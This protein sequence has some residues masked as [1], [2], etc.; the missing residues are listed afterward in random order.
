LESSHTLVTPGLRTAARLGWRDGL[1]SAVTIVTSQPKLW[2]LGMVG[3]SLRGGILLLLLPIIVLPTQVEVRLLLGH[4]LGS[5]GFTTSFWGILVALAVFASLLTVGALLI[6]ARIELSSFERVIADPEIAARTAYKPVRVISGA[7]RRLFLR[8]FAVQVLA[9]IALIACAAP[10]AWSVVQTSYTEVTR[11]TSTAP[12]YERVLGTV[13]EQL[14]FLL[15][16]LV[17]IEMISSLTSRELLV[18]AFGWR[19]RTSTRRLWIIP[20]LAAAATYPFRSPVRSLGTSVVNWTLTAVVVISSIWA[21]SVAWSAVR[22]AFLT[23]VSF[24]DVSEDAG[25]LLAALGLSTVFVLAICLTGFA[26]ALRAALWSVDRL[27]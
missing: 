16:A 24:S 18:R 15:I 22:G 5:T 17:V 10:V 12:I 27:R 26:S 3:F 4:Y 9:F 20:A 13:G 19:E 8:L 14:F 2:L 6:L 7:R 1:A 11:P 21:L 23:S 25:M